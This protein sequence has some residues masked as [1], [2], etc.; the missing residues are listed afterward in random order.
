MAYGKLY[1]DFWDEDDKTADPE[2]V[3][4]DGALMAAF[5]FSGKHRN[6]IGCFKLGMGAIT[7]IPRF[8]AWGIGRVSKA[9][10]EL[11]D[12]GLI[13]R[14]ER[15]GWTLIRNTLKRDP[16][17][18]PKV[19][20]HAAK[21]AHAIPASSIVYPILIER[22]VPQITEHA[23][24]LSKAKLWPMRNP[25]DTPSIPHP[26]PYRFPEPEPEPEPEPAA[27]AR[28]PEPVTEIVSRETSLEQAEAR[29]ICEAFNAEVETIFTSHTHLPH[30]TNY[31]TALSMVREDFTAD[32]CRPVFVAVLTR[33]CAGGKAPPSSL[34]YFCKPLADAKAAANKAMPEGNADD[35]LVA[36]LPAHLNRQRAPNNFD[37]AVDAA[38]SL[39]AGG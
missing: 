18:G 33:M 32:F 29:R 34:S 16:I 3:S 38:R 8:G 27:A 26:I 28:A 5:L 12:T 23:E 11:V 39:V 6:A 36:T 35:H 17:V 13:L 31:H 15:T 10:R 1:D 21:L 25:I 30:T 4:D 9:I 14:D 7:D 20:V 22:L 19:A 24:T 2:R 37:R